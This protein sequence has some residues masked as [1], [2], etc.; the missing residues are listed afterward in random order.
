MRRV[1][2]LRNALP[3]L[4]V[5]PAELLA[6]PELGTALLALKLLETGGGGGLRG[7]WVGGVWRGVGGWLVGWL[8]GGF[9]GGGGEGP[10]GVGLGKKWNPGKWKHGPKP[11]GGG[12]GRVGWWGIVGL[13]LDLGWIWVGFGLVCFGLFWF[14]L[15]FVGLFA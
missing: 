2:F 9:R 8:G 13:V 6:L 5:A 12:M 3:R 10:R 7:G 14:V 15:V 1:E 4:G 11:G